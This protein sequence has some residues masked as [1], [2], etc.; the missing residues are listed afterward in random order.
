MCV[1]VCVY[2]YTHTLTLCTHIFIRIYR[3]PLCHLDE[4]R[5]L[6]GVTWPQLSNLVCPELGP[7]QIPSLAPPLSLSLSLAPFAHPPVWAFWNSCLQCVTGLCFFPLFQFP[8]APLQLF[9]EAP[10][11]VRYACIHNC[12]H[13]AYIHNCKKTYKYKFTVNVNIHMHIYI[14]MHNRHIC[15]YLLIYR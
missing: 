2:I 12:T 8:L 3:D 10:C 6:S 11:F 5:W 4:V 1:Y 7:L 9:G 15:I 13:T 14:H